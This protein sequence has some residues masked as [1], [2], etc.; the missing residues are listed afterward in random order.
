TAAVVG[1]GVASVMTLRGATSGL[2]P[3]QPHY[4]VNRQATY[5][6]AGVLLM[7]ALS[8]IDYS[9]LRRLHGAIYGLLLLMILAVLAIG[10]TARGSQRAINLPF[11]SF[12]ASEVGKVLLIIAIAAFVVDRARRLRERETTARV[13]IAALVPAMFV[14]AQPDPGSGMVYTV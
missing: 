1:L 12:Q 9:R 13:M 3:A 5:L 10:H 2:I 14:I 8:R 11:F 4:Y 6:I 7:L